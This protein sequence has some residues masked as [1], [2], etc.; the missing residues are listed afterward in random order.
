MVLH[1]RFHQLLEMSMKFARFK[2]KINQKFLISR[3]H[4]MY[5]RFTYSGIKLDSITASK[6]RLIRSSDNKKIVL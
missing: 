1:C 2:T 6:T 3:S 4:F 5:Q